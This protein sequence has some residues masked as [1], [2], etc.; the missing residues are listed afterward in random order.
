MTSLYKFLI[1][2]SF[3][4]QGI[5]MRV[6]IVSPNPPWSL[7]GVEKVIKETVLHL[8][9]YHK[10]IN[11]EIWCKGGENTFKK[12]KGIPV[13]M[14]KTLPFGLSPALIKE[15]KKAQKQFDVI[16]IHG[17]SDLHLFEALLTIKEWRKA[18]ISSHYH[19]Q[20]STLLFKLTK[21]IYDKFIIS[22]CLKK[23]KKIIC[24]SETEKRLILKKFKIPRDKIEVIYNG[25][26]IE[27]IRSF[28]SNKI[29]NKD[30]I[31]I[32]YFGRLKK[33]KNIHIIIEALKY[34]PNRFVFYI[35]GKGSYEKYLRNLTE[36]LGLVNRVKFLG[37]LSE[38]ELYTILHSVDVVINLSEIEAFGIMVVE[39]L[40][41]GK[42]VIVNN[43]LGLGELACLFQE[44]VFPL[45]NLEPH[46]IA[47][48]TKK[49]A[50][51]KK[52]KRGIIKKFDW[53]VISD[54]YFDLYRSVNMRER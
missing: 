37:I 38:K 8:K 48:I 10:D 6:L 2:S 51:E 23:T 12:W 26:P 50:F 22:K 17:T 28:K 41:A 7:G 54:K 15:L 18:V 44:G 31:L 11:L 30:K 33:H 47:E 29:S 5:K 46:R 43:K 13:R 14:F 9:K 49:V 4:S 3:N 32:L 19:P 40:A 20:G 1:L 53:N 25:V 42:P 35:V 36:R 52:I 24:V 34:L 27:E 39:S 16:H 21:P 45:N